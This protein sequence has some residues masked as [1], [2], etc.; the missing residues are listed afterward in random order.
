MRGRDFTPQDSANAPAVAIINETLARRFFP[1][2]DP[3]G[4]R[5]RFGDTTSDAQPCEIV[6]IVKDTLI[7]LDDQSLRAVTYRPLAQQH[8]QRLTL[9]VHTDGNPQALFAAVRR[10]VQALDENVPAQEIKTLDEFI[11]FTF[12]PMQMGARLVGAFGLLGLL[13]A[14]V[15]LYGVMSLRGCRTYAEIVCVWRLGAE[16]REVFALIVGQGLVLTLFGR[17]QVGAWPLWRRA[18]C[19][20]FSSALA[21]TDRSR[22][23]GV[24]LL[25]TLVA[26]L[27]CWIPARRATQVDPLVALRHE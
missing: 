24:A 5:L 8:S 25:L 23:L 18:S 20:G 14:S 11:A 4:K 26:L 3:I 9:L 7:R 16:R 17:V 21:R 13:L 10:E 1:N 12:W 2:E 15:G 22:F 27:A 6:G 19:G